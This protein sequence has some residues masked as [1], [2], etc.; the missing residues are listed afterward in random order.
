MK[1]RALFHLLM[2][3]IRSFPKGWAEP[4]FVE[5]LQD[6]LEITHKRNHF[7]LCW[8]WQ[9]KDL[10]I[11][12]PSEEFE[13]YGASQPG[14]RA[15]NWDRAVALLEDIIR[16]SDGQIGPGGL[17]DT[18]GQAG[19]SLSPLPPGGI[20]P[21]GV[22]PG[23]R[24]VAVLAAIPYFLGGSP[25]VLTTVLAVVTATLIIEFLGKL[26]LS[27]A[28][29]RVTL[30]DG[31]FVSAGCMAPAFVPISPVPALFF[32]LAVLLIAKFEETGNRKDFIS[33]FVAGAFIGMAVSFSSSPG[34]A[35][36]YSLAALALALAFVLAFLALA[37]LAPVRVKPF[38]PVVM[39]LGIG[40]VLL[41]LP[42]AGFVSP[43]PE[44]GDSGPGV[45]AA[46]YVLAMLLLYLCIGWS[47][48]GTLHL[49]APWIALGA[50]F[51]HFIGAG[52]SG[53]LQDF[54]VIAGPVLVSA[55]R[56]TRTLLASA[57][58]RVIRMK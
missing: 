47:L 16:I 28:D 25:D 57:K 14:A 33:W 19:A 52:I 53:G 49:M 7:Y 37:V 35:G 44:S 15:R 10:E 32:M 18:E 36:G 13:F 40:L 31:L 8:R 54:F 30:V 58:P 42:L 23:V 5:S 12:L 38:Q 9:G 51:I 39:L 24:A 43:P 6:S 1:H 2:I 29:Y 11:D 17:T 46:S 21:A 56:M 55:A 41:L 3:R 26:Y 4:D 48:M 50:L 27:H 22:R 34:P 45:S 20:A